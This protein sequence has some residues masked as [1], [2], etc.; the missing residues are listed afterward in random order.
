MKRLALL[1]LAAAIGLVGCGPEEPQEFAYETGE[2]IEETGEE[3]ARATG[4]AMEEAGEEIRLAFDDIDV[5]TDTRVT[6]QEL[7]RWW[8]RNNP[9]DTWDVDADGS[10]VESELHVRLEAGEF[11]ELD[12]NDDGRLTEAEV[13]GGLF[14][15]LDDNGD[16]AI[17]REEWPRTT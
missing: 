9:F 8:N 7:E 13:Q 4:E 11:A 15:V 16:G 2:E 6:E 10:L 17:T 5:D 1:G 14:D 3:A 12:A